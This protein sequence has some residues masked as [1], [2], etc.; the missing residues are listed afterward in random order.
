MVRAH[1]IQNS[2]TCG[3]NPI[4]GTNLPSLDPLI[5]KNT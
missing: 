5:P 4:N 1:H 3:Y 2:S